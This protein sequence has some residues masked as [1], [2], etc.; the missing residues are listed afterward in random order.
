MPD[1]TFL[2]ATDRTWRESREE[3]IASTTIPSRIS[4]RVD[5]DTET[6]C[7]LVTG[8]TT[9]EH[10]V[11]VALFTM[12]CYLLSVTA[13]LGH[14]QRMRLSKGGDEIVAIAATPKALT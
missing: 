6:R 3:S 7:M 13:V 5:S 10:R 8:W 1:M 9:L 12:P 11:H 2:V 4:Y 14:V